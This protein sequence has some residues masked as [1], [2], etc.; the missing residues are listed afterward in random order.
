MGTPHK[1]KIG[2]VNHGKPAVNRHSN[3]LVGESGTRK[4]RAT[5]ECDPR[6]IRVFRAPW[7]VFLF[8][9]PASA[10][11][12]CN[13]RG[14][15]WQDKLPAHATA[16]CGTNVTANAEATVASGEMGLAWVATVVAEA[17]FQFGFLGVGH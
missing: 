4:E 16:V 14:R 1:T 17:H 15:S 10:C 8:S 12:P 11:V 9:G 6:R 5:Q 13:V 3:E 2:P 7:P